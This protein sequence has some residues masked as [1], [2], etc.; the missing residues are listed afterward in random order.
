MEKIIKSED[1]YITAIVFVKTPGQLPLK[2]RK[3]TNTESQIQKFIDYVKD[4]W[5]VD[6]INWYS[7]KKKSFI[8]QTK[9]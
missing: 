5:P 4:R 8:E 3:I 1:Y 2:Y 6:H 7:H 9:F